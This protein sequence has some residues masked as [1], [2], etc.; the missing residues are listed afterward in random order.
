M[1][2]V[3]KLLWKYVKKLDKIKNKKH[4]IGIYINIRLLL[5]LANDLY[6][7][8]SWI[9]KTTRL[10]QALMEFCWRAFTVD[11]PWLQLL[12]FPFDEVLFIHFS[13]F[14][15]SEMFTNNVWVPSGPA[16]GAY[17][18]P[19]ALPFQ[20]YTSRTT[21]QTITQTHIQAACR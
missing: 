21:T 18:P 16:F 15:T 11:I 2:Y 14:T 9:C 10:F 12:L 7:W 5:T 1:K 13:R 6:I 4:N 19:W 8:I 17:G 3:E 20:L